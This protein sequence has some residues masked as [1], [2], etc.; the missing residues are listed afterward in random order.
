[1]PI[2]LDEIDIRHNQELSSNQ[3]YIPDNSS[4]DQSQCCSKAEALLV[5]DFSFNLIPLEQAIT[6]HFGRKCD[7]AENGLIAVKKYE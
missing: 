4:S 1:M 6:K 5:D 2:D 7:I 3:E